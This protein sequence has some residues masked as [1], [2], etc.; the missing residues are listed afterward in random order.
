MEKF[1]KTLLKL[2]NIKKDLTPMQAKAVSYASIM[3]QIYTLKD[4]A[5]DIE[6]ECSLQDLTIALTEV[7]KKI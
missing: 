2:Y 1:E 4:M 3:E 5:K 7:S 6:K